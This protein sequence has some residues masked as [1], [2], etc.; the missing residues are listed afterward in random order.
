M[1]LGGTVEERIAGNLIKEA[2][3]GFVL[4]DLSRDASLLDRFLTSFENPST[5][6]LQIGSNAEAVFRAR[7]HLTDREGVKGSAD[8]VVVAHGLEIERGDL[9]TAL[10]DLFDQAISLQECKSLLNGL[11]GNT[12]TSGELFL[13]QVN[14]SGHAPVADLINDCVIDPVRQAGQLVKWLH[15]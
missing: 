7:C 13:H 4:A 11:A 14:A 5:T 10:T 9:L 6:P 3:K 2:V 12:E 1:R 15:R 8:I